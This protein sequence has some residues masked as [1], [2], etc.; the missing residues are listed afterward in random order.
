MTMHATVHTLQITLDALCISQRDFAR[1]IGI[2]LGSAHRLIA[3]VLPRRNANAVRLR[4]V[5]YLKARG[6]TP[7][8]LGSLL[9]PTKKEAPA[10]TPAEALPTTTGNEA[11]KENDMLLQSAHLTEKARKHFGLPRSPFVDDVQSVADVFKSPAIRYARA[12]L[13]DAAKNSGFMALVGESGSGKTTLVEELE[14]QV[15][16]SHPDILIVKP[17][18]LAM[19][20]NDQRGKTLK[21]SHIAEAI[22]AALDPNVKTRSSPQ[23]R[24][25]QLHELL[26]ASRRAGRRHLLVIEEA[27]CLP[28]PTLKHLKR[29]AELKDG[30]QRL[31]GV[32]LI[33]QPELAR[34]LTSMNSEIR[35]VAQRCD[36]ITLEPLDA[37]L[38]SYL[39]H[40]FERFGLR[41]EQ[42]FAADAADAIRAR[43]V[44]TDRNSKRVTSICYP[45]AVQNLVS[46]AMNIAAEVGWP[47]VDAQAVAGC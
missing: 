34:T 31:M 9:L 41:Y 21:A 6:A 5:E 14:E 37:E 2:G 22:V 30:M 32:A 26:K 35:E 4:A 25:L 20:L 28:H 19:E 23:A 36:V 40:K 46:R 45:L 38:E 10:D 8:Q 15:N 13:M 44:M 29:F 24:F 12:A 27:H 17:Y 11:S 1:G 18:V 47:Q 7:P 39:R 43:L 42:V 3:G 33:A 16:A